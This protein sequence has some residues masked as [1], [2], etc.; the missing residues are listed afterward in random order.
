LHRAG[1]GAPREADETFWSAI[2]TAVAD[3]DPEVR[4]AAI[5]AMT[6]TEW[7]RFAPVL[8]TLARDDREHAVRKLAK[9]A[10]AATENL[11][12]AVR[13]QPAPSDDILPADSAA[14]LY[15][16]AMHE[17]DKVIAQYTRDH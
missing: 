7:P 3:P 15:T 4:T 8:R 14:E 16:I 9:R 17:L 1:Y 10:A 6:A 13:P 2:T 11:D 5:W 12:P